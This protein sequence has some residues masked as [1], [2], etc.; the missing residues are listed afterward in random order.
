MKIQAFFRV[1]NPEKRFPIYIKKEKI[2]KIP[3]IMNYINN[4]KYVM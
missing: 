1:L 3:S 2:K 4:E